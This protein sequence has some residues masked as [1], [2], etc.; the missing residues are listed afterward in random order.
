[1]IIQSLQLQPTTYFEL[2]ELGA[3]DG[4]KTKELLKVL[5]QSG[6]QFKYIPIDISDNALDQLE[7]SIKKD[8]DIPI[9]KKQGDYFE[10]LESL[11]QINHPKVV[12]FLG[13]NIGNL[14]D[15]KS[16]DFAKKLGDSLNKND[17][18]LLGV[19]LIK[20][21][22]IVLPAYNDSQGITSRF[23]L[24][25]LSRINKDLGGNFNL[26]HFDHLPEYNEDEGIARSYLV[27]KVEQ[28][29][30][31]EALNKTFHFEKG[32]RIHTE[33]SRKYNDS[34]LH[35]ILENSGLNIVDK[36]TDSNGYFADYILKKS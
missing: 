10:V 36:L 7:A 24:N 21:A 6:Y 15:E 19:D 34:I 25:V 5:K 17:K 29:V 3:G 35:S 2:I 26:E 33:T 14:S 18:V 4:T 16:K 13:S 8:I 1:M 12:L 11:K 22:A 20:D 32:E 30:T 31:I 9:E 27:S 28:D 23:N